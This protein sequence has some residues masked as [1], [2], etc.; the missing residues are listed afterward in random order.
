MAKVSRSNLELAVELASST[1]PLQGHA[2]VDSVSGRVIS[3][4]DDYRPEDDEIPEDLET[5]ERYLAVPTKRDLDLGHVLVEQFVAEQ[6]P[7]D[8]ERVRGYFRNRGAYRRF[9]DL[10]EERDKTESWYAFESGAMVR[11]LERWCSEN[12]MELADEDPAA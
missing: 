6:L 9:R 3:F 7:R 10:L 5:N 11:A 1:G 2:Y 4:T 12:G 8:V